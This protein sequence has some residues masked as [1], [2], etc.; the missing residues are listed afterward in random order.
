MKLPLFRTRGKRLTLLVL[1][2]ALGSAALWRVL[3][4]DSDAVD[5]AIKAKADRLRSDIQDYTPPENNV[6]DTADLPPPKQIQP[7]KKQPILGGP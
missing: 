4:T 7:S 1:A 2:A 5:P 3:H 6:P